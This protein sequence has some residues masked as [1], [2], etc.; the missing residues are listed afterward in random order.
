LAQPRNEDMYGE[1]NEKSVSTWNECC[2]SARPSL[3]YSIQKKV[4]E[5]SKARLPCRG[6]DFDCCEPTANSVN[7]FMFCSSN[8][9]R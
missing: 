1:K 8:G 5:L 4:D 7:H 9:F 3:V 6:V 2:R